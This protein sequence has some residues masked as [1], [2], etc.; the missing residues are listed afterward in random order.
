MLSND[1]L[2]LTTSQ[3]MELGVNVVLKPYLAAKLG[4]LAVA[5]PLQ[6]QGIGEQLMAFVH[7]EILDSASLSAARLVILDADNDARVISFYKRMR[8]QD[9]LWAETQVRNHG[10]GGK[11]GTVLSTV[12]MTRDI[13]AT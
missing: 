5:E 4:R 8:Y 2:A 11:K 1:S 10:H 6:G 12:K 9:S 7:G 13:L 3:Q